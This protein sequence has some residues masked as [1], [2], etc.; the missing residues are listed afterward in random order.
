MRLQNKTAIITG[1]GS[2]IGLAIAKMFIK[3]G[4]NVCAS[5]HKEEDIE[6]LSRELNTALVVK[7]DVT[8]NED[9]GRTVA[10]CVE[11]FG[12]VNI[13]VNNAGIYKGA[14]FHEMTEK[15]WDFVM[16]ADLKGVYRCT[17]AV[18]SKMLE[19]EK[20]KI[21]N[22][23][24]I[25]GLIGFAGSSAY[26]AAKGAVVNLTR[27][28]ALEYAVKKINVNCICPGVIKTKMTEPFLNDPKMKARLVAAIP[29]PRIGEPEDIAYL[30]VYL[31]SDE[32]DFMTG[33]II[34]IDGGQIA[35]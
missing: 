15:D 3:E 33:A 34:P 10:K 22:I 14:S 7:M 16:D 19:K 12:G 26:C 23:A 35:Q 4:A 25:A 18:L 17:K 13:L 11:K 27:D 2:G 24:S 32:S 9:V 30:A 5:V 29:Y 31:A 28:L 6:N 21:I 1:A 8:K 20:G